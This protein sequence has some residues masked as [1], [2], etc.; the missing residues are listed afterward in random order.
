MKSRKDAMRT[1]YNEHMR[2]GEGTV[3]LLHLQEGE[4][5]PPH[6]RLHAQITVPAGAS[7]GYHVHEG[8]TEVFHFIAGCGHVD[9]NG[10]MT[11]VEPG[12]IIS[13]P[14]GCGHAVFA[15]EGVDLT[16]DAVINLNE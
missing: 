14:S 9:D 12:D 4:T 13:T 5:L 1:Q 10:T 15:D 11:A 16:F 2:G 3:T 7:I 8:E 6:C